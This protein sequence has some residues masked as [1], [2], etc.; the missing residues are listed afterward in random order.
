MSLIARLPKNR[1][2]KRMVSKKKMEKDE[3]IRPSH[4]LPFPDDCPLEHGGFCPDGCRFT[5][6]SLVG[7][8]KTGVMPDP[9]KRCPLRQV[10]GL[11]SEW[12]RTRPESSPVVE[13]DTPSPE[14][15]SVGATCGTCP[16]WDAESQ[17]CYSTAYFEHKA[18][19]WYIGEDPLKKCLRNNELPLPRHSGDNRDAPPRPPGLFHNLKSKG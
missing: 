19:P 5:T 3:Y 13:E 1:N 15:E 11:F 9:K 7:L 2:P 8:I 6:D 4:L 17:R 16:A 14:P 10:C 18:G 12:P